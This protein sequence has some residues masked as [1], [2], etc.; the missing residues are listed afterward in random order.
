MNDIRIFRSEGWYVAEIPSL[1]VV[2]RARNI[3]SLRKNLTE[4]ID[5]AVEGL[6]ALK[7]AKVKDSKVMIA[8][9]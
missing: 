6:I 2:I 8:N 1:H 4:A 3:T 9:A 7:S 5:V